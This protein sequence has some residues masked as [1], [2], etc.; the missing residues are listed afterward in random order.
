MSKGLFLKI[1]VAVILGIYWNLTNGLKYTRSLNTIQ[2]LIPS[3]NIWDNCSDRRVKKL[4]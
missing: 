4:Q 1:P 2:K 3:S